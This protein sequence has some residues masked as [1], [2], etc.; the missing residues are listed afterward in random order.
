MARA[1]ET[2][3]PLF[4]SKSECSPGFGSDYI[5]VP[6]VEERIYRRWFSL[7]LK[8]GLIFVG[9]ALLGFWLAWLTIRA[10]NK[11]EDSLMKIWIEEELNQTS[12]DQRQSRQL[13]A[14][15]NE[16]DGLLHFVC[17]RGQ[18]INRLESVHS[19][20]CADRRWGFGCHS[21]PTM[22]TCSWT[23][24]LN[25]PD[26]DMG[27]QECQGNGVISGF[28]STHSNYYEDRTWKMKCCTSTKMNKHCQWTEYINEY[29][30]RMNYQ[31][32]HMYHLVGI[33][34]THSESYNDRKWKLKICQK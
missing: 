9:V 30:A 26:I 3:Q 8:Y 19:W 4:P 24:I 7:Y 10:G 18:A 21:I 28:I 33:K 23:R 34:N 29:H 27:P 16:L 5:K 15:S 12:N 14:Y 32:P 22:G 6:P 25:T 2:C 1:P 17:P 20:W 13:N 11:K 31:L